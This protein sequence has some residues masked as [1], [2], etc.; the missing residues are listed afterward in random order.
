MRHVALSK[1]KYKALQAQLVWAMSLWWDFPGTIRPQK[2]TTKKRAQ[3]CALFF[4]GAFTTPFPVPLLLRKVLIQH[5][6]WLLAYPHIKCT[7]FCQMKICVPA[8]PAPPNTVD[9]SFSESI[10]RAAVFWPD[11]PIWIW[12]VKKF[13]FFIHFFNTFLFIC[14]YYIT[15]R[16]PSWINTD[17]S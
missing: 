7:F 10:R 17:F 14:I 2:W 9:T 5:F 13:A 6:T 1:S 4:C 12:N 3:V 8:I 15:K 16:K 11:I